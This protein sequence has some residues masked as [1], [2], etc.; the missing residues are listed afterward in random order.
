MKGGRGLA[1]AAVI[2]LGLWAWSKGKKGAVAVPALTSTKAPAT[3]AETEQ[4]TSQVASQLSAIAA[5]H[6]ED[7][8]LADHMSQAI[9]SAQQTLELGM[10]LKEDPGAQISAQQVNAYQQYK[11]AG[12]TLDFETLTLYRDWREWEAIVATEKEAGRSL[13]WEEAKVVTEIAKA[14]NI[15]MPT[16]PT[17][18][19]PA[20]P[21]PPPPPVPVEEEEYRIWPAPPLP[22]VQLSAGG[23]LSI[24]RLWDAQ[25]ERYLP[26][27]DYVVS[28]NLAKFS[29]AITNVLDGEGLLQ[30]E[31]RDGPGSGRVRFYNFGAKAQLFVHPEPGK[32]LDY[33]SWLHPSEY[34]W[35]LLSEEW[36]SL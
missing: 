33:P 29:I 27:A 14:A 19:E 7:P 20:P 26:H 30:S 34:G 6:P 31:R 5:Q 18:T 1:I 10:S 15:P 11:A 2:G 12:G 22:K 25:W 35:Q 23:T 3:V 13:T 28:G 21:P 4:M 8:T 16:E 32:T 36:Y 17:I 24:V 9:A